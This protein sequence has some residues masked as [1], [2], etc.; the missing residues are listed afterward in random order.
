MVGARGSGSR[1][2]HSI[3]LFSHGV[4]E[5]E[6]ICGEQKGELFRASDPLPRVKENERGGKL[7][8]RKKRKEGKKPRPPPPEPTSRAR[9]SSAEQRKRLRERLLTPLFFSLAG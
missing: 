3:Y 6:K 8:K 7:G 1:G 9:Q 4:D 2:S 5:I